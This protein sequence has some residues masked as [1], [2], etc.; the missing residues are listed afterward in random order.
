M[1][2]KRK[3]VALWLLLL[4]AAW[5]QPNHF[6]P[7]VS[8]HSELL[9]FL[10]FGI[11]FAMTVA[12]R[13]RANSFDVPGAAIPILLLLAL[14]ALQGG[15]GVTAY[16]GD[17]AVFVMYIVAMILAV[18]VGR[19]CGS[20]GRI[21]QLA[22]GILLAGGLSVV[23]AAL[24]SM[25]PT[26]QY[27]LVNPMPNW[28]RPGANLAQPNHLGT[29]LLWA[30]VSAMYLLA[31]KKITTHLALLLGAVLLVGVAMTESRT[32][33]LGV[34]AIAIWAGFHY[35]QG[36]ASRRWALSLGFASVG[37]LMFTLW[38]I[39]VTGF[40]E[41][42]WSAGTGGVNTQAGERFLVWPQLIAAV[43]E[44][45][46]LGW[47]A[48]GVSVAHNAVLDRYDD[49]APFTY[50]HN[51][52]LDLAVGFGIPVTLLLM[53]LA[54]VWCFRRMRHVRSSSDWY[55]IALL[56]P[57]GLHSML[58]FPYAYAYFLLPACFAI[59]VL[60]TGRA[61]I[62]AMRLSSGAATAILIAWAVVGSIAARDYLLAE[63][64]FRVA[65]FEALKVGQTPISYERPHL[66]LLNQLDAMNAATRV[67][68]TPD[69]SDSEIELLKKAAARFPW[70]AI[71]HRYALALALNDNLPEAQRQLK[72]MRAMHGE[73]IHEA[74]VAQ[75]H[76]WANEKYPQLR[77]IASP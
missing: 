67:V 23:V 8:F 26:E 49:A 48:R 77:G 64:D 1:A 65:R 40:Q 28:R 55:A 76:A 33:M 61:S 3:I 41:A 4:G 70:T 57:F 62:G 19:L 35:F 36:L 10:A 54:G 18:I 73:K 25:H 71:Q 46:W 58:E 63:E 21:Y 12:D 60:D 27:A 31:L 9:A 43:M 24:Q 13:T 11:L 20:D 29:L 32:A 34:F 47:G 14:V 72:V 7:W 51:V 15:V 68:P 45:P 30:L 5:L 39:F 2:F 69:M 44:R 75:W 74:I 37:L 16:S 52:I 38:P 53:G 6:S 56:I 17:T 59:G 22:W 66:L 50:A 42:G